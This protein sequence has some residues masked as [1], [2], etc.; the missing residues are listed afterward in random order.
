MT[1]IPVRIGMDTAKSV[2]QL[3]GVDENEAVVVKQPAAAGG[4]DPLL[5]KAAADAGGDRV[6][7]ALAPRSAPTRFWTARL[8]DDF[9]RRLKRS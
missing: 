7:R 4:D 9:W 1:N 2:F 5:H 8:S 3:H 6:L